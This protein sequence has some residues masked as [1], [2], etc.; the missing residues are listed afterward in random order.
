M[1][2]LALQVQV[3]TAAETALQ[4]KP[5]LM[6]SARRQGKSLVPPQPLGQGNTSHRPGQG[7]Q[8]LR[9]ASALRRE[10]GISMGERQARDP[11][12]QTLRLP[13]TRHQHTALHLAEMDKGHG[14]PVRVLVHILRTDTR[15]NLL[16][17]GSDPLIV[18]ATL[19][20][21]AQDLALTILLCTMGGQPTQCT[22]ATIMGKTW[23]LQALVLIQGC[24][25][26][27]GTEEC[28]MA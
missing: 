21:P 9:T 11:M 5:L 22:P 13:K 26:S 12:L 25:R 20:A 23:A 6:V 19:V 24:A 10:T 2:G 16:H 4:V 3:L 15:I 1:R 17:T 7:P 8:H 14:M 28:R 18:K 27:S